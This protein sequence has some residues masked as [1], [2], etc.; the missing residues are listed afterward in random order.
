MK[1]GGNCKLNIEM[2]LKS[3]SYILDLDHVK[4][5]LGLFFFSELFNKDFFSHQVLGSTFIFVKNI[6][7]QAANFMFC[8]ISP[9]AKTPL[10][11]LEGQS[12]CNGL[13]LMMF[14]RLG[15]KGC[16]NQSVNNKVVSRTAPAT[17]GL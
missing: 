14:L 4:L 2:A 13:G 8:L 16:L 15:G 1:L 3:R 6:H 17:P 11:F 7:Q 9:V 10:W 5:S 12:S